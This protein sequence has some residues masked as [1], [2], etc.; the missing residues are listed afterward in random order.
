MKVYPTPFAGKSSLF[1]VTGLDVIA[2]VCVY[3]RCRL[4][5]I[6][7]TAFAFRIFFIAPSAM[8]RRSGHFFFAN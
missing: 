8:L 5:A 2:P 6:A 1:F 7:W 4:F 3:Q